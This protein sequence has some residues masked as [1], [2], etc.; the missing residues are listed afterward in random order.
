MQRKNWRFL[1]LA[2]AIAATSLSAHAQTFSATFRGST[3]WFIDGMN[4][5]F[6]Q[7]APVTE[8]EVTLDISKFSRSAGSYLIAP[9]G[10]TAKISFPGAF[11]AL[12]TG[13]TLSF[14]NQNVGY[15]SPNGMPTGF[16]NQRLFTEP[17]S[18]NPFLSISG[19]SDGYF[20]KF[21]VQQIA[22]SYLQSIDFF[23][24]GNAPVVGGVTNPPLNGAAVNS[25][26]NGV[27]NISANQSVGPQNYNFS[28]MSTGPDSANSHFYL[29][30]NLGVSSV[31]PPPPSTLTPKNIIVVTH[32]WNSAA[33][34]L[35]EVTAAI[36]QRVQ[37][38]GIGE[39]T[40]VVDFRWSQANSGFGLDEYTRAYSAT[41]YAGTNL[42]LQIGKI[43]QAGRTVDPNYDPQIHLVGHSLGT[44]VN[45]YAA[46]TLA[47]IATIEQ[48]TILDAPLNSPS[49]FYYENLKKGTVQYVEN[50][51]ASDVADLTLKFGAPIAGTGPCSSIEGTPLCIGAEVAGT[52]HGTIHSS[53]YSGLVGT[54]GWK[55]PLL[56]GWTPDLAWDPEA[57]AANSD[58]LRKYFAANVQ[59][60][61][62][63]TLAGEV[64]LDYRGGIP[65][66]TLTPHSPASFGLQ[67]EIPTD[68]EALNFD[69]ALSKASMGIVEVSFANQRL[70]T[71]YSGDMPDGMVTADLD[72][73]A[74]AGQ[75][76][77]LVLRYTPTGDLDVA[78]VSN[79]RFAVAVPEPSQT[80]LLVLGIS[81]LLK[82]QALR[83][84]RKVK[85]NG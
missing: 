42:A 81:V 58:H 3:G 80:A 35:P 73:S 13:S 69:L 44:R 33:N 66:I 30:A 19:P 34:G 74:F 78:T 29:T 49:S 7:Y 64:S 1:Q 50:Y 57:L 43:I 23:S 71:W 40:R 63:D 72:V 2:A 27:G 24:A 8:V 68:A 55:S 45:A 16:M 61:S 18:N 4:H 82:G 52:T 75:S 56:S 28:L 6:S 32:G 25:I 17:V 48:V 14:S 79:L 84:R 65:F 12:P 59:A 31:A 10:M 36:R 22:G 39:D 15:W 9:G 67:L 46:S 85:F 83:H 20:S 77:Q 54:S 21:Q 60:N 70:W 47:G 51:Y 5:D 37:A 53:F 41:Q 11:G 76:G 62:L 26:F 38:E